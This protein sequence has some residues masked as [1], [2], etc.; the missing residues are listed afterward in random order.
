MSI[1]DRLSTLIRAN[2]NDMLDRA[3][4]PE[5]MLS[6]ILRDM[7]SEIGKART[8][9]AEMMAQEKLFRDDLKSE[10][11]RS[12]YMEDR[13]EHYVRDGNDAMAREAL[14]RKADADAN[15]SVL[16]QQLQAQSD[17]VTRLRSQLDALVEKHQQAVGN[18]DNLLARHRRAKAQQQV[19]NTMRDLDITDYSGELA[20]MERRIRQSEAMASAETELNND[21]MA[22]DTG[23]VFD[24]MERETKVDS[25][26]AALKARLGMSDGGSSGGDSTRGETVNLGGSQGNQG[27]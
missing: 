6:Q 2:I 4:D 10:R 17:M 24:D 12:G 20:R 25:D 19:S 13:A 21:M 11:E 3:E 9:V 8:Q 23:S 7:E 22:D 5:I 1:F 18:R 16:D 14:K 26:L 15:I 27:S